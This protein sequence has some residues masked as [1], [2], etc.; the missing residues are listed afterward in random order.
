MKNFA[1]CAAAAAVLLLAARSAG[2]SSIPSATGAIAPAGAPSAPKAK[3]A[4]YLPWGASVAVSFSPTKMAAGSLST[5]TMTLTGFPGTD[6]TGV[7]I[8]DNF[9]T[10]MYV[11][12]GS[13]AKTTCGGTAS[14]TPYTETSTGALVGS[15]LSLKNGKRDRLPV[16]YRLG[17]GEAQIW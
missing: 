5:L 1:S 6:L 10:N 4:M 8:T 12:T 7:S 14:W 11:I 2:T 15:S 9:P 16:V 3:P 17:A 13:V